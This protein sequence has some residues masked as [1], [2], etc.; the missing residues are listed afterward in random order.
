MLRLIRV[1]ILYLEGVTTMVAGLLTLLA[2][3]RMMSV[4]TTLEANAAA[5]DVARMLGVAWIV[6][7]LV[8]CLLPRVRAAET[9]RVLLLPLLIGDV[10]HLAALWPWSPGSATHVIPSLIY[11]LNRGSIA[12]RPEAFLGTPERNTREDAERRAD[13]GRRADPER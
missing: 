8:V 13:S 5:E 3:E 4:L 10:L 6:I 11:L 12:L 9:L 1:S 2:P 7:G